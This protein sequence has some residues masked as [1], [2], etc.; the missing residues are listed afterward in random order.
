MTKQSLVISINRDIGTQAQAVLNDMGLDI[1]TVVDY[2][3]RQVVQSKRITVSIDPANQ[4]PQANLNHFVETNNIHKEKILYQLFASVDDSLF[5]INNATGKP[6]RF[7]GWEG[8]VVMADDFNA[9]LDDFED[10]M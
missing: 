5:D 8:K 4:I 3:L 7:G 2:F 6:V 1:A 9:P 10:Y